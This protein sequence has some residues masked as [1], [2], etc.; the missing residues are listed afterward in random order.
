MLVKNVFLPCKKSLDSSLQVLAIR[1]HTLVT[2]HPFS[3]LSLRQEAGAAASKI[4]PPPLY[5]PGFLLACGARRLYCPWQQK[6]WENQAYLISYSKV[7]SRKAAHRRG[8]MV[9]SEAQS[10]VTA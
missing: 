1:D 4:P 3:S 8:L 7:G 6:D 9:Y 2:V 5:S 10:T